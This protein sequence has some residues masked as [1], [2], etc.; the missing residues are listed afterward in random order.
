ML[1]GVNFLNLC[2]SRVRLEH[3][4]EQHAVEQHAVEQHAVEH[5][6][7]YVEPLDLA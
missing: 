7:D 5:V 4:V 2:V 6:V 1:T 3:A